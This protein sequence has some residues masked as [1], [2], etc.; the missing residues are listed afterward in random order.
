MKSTLLVADRSLGRLD[1]CLAALAAACLLA[2]MGVTFVDVFMRYALNA[3]LRWSFD[4]ITNYLL[5]A[6]F[7][8]GFAFALGRNEHVAV[9]YFA[10]SLPPS[11]YHWGVGVGFL[12]ASLM[13]A[14]VIWLGAAET[15]HAWV[16]NE[17]LMGAY[18]WPVWPAKA[19]IPIG[20]I[21][22]L[23]RMVHRG[24]AHLAA[25]GDAT[26]RAPLRLALGKEPLPK[27]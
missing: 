27:E 13:F 1:A 24:I 20:L 23:L 8:F 26:L 5:T 7:F 17:S 12:V 25:A 11:L 18:V 4:L 19:V 15:W 21:P 9:D 10:R 16:E 22:L 2:M 14:V 3:P 6:S